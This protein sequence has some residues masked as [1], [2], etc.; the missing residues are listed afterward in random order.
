M[1]TNYAEQNFG[2]SL[3]AITS[4]DLNRFFAVERDE[5]DTLE[6]KSYFEQ[7][8]NH[9]THKQNAVLKTICAFLNSSGGLLVWGAPVGQTVTGRQNKIFVGDL[10]PVP[11]LIE[12][13]TFISRVANS[14]YP[15]SNLVRMHRVEIAPDKYVYIFDV[16]QSLHKPHQFDN[17]YWVRSDGQS[18]AAPHYLI[19]ALFK[20]IR[21]PNLGGYIKFYKATLVTRNVIDLQ[22]Q[23]YVLNHSKDQNEYDTYFSITSSQ[24]IFIDNSRL[25]LLDLDGHQYRRDDVSKILSYSHGPFHNTTLRINHPSFTEK[26]IEL[27]LLFGGRLSPM[28]QSGYVL[29]FKNFN[30][31]GPSRPQNVEL[32]FEISKEVNIPMVDT[33]LSEEERIKLFLGY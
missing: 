21:Y 28:K 16:S 29:T 13:D 32:M 1:E 14:I 8:Q 11:T 10:S 9:H 12:K 27:V 6:F 15:L 4:A 23:I 2:K 25:G 5:S 3:T 33:G 7:G 20:Q 26:P 31:F 24:G 17:R 22:L 18:N 30:G 19:D